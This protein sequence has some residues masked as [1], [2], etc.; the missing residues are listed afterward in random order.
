MGLENKKPPPLQSK[1]HYIFYFFLIHLGGIAVQIWT[2][3][4]KLKNQEEFKLVIY[5]V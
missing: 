1:I 3:D 4:L 5:P 2:T